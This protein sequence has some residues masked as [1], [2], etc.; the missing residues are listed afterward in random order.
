MKPLIAKLGEDTPANAGQA[1]TATT[2]LWLQQVIDP[3]PFC[4]EM[5]QIT[6]PVSTQT[7]HGES[8]FYLFAFLTPIEDIC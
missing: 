2:A 1:R 5:L 8:S 7:F 6:L 3:A 4:S